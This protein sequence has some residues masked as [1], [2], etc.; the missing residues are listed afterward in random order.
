MDTVQRRDRFAEEIRRLRETYPMVHLRTWTPDDFHAAANGPDRDGKR[1]EADWESPV[2]VGT[3]S[4]L[5]KILDENA[6]GNWLA[7]RRAIRQAAGGQ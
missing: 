4:E 1:G 7:V 2:H 3:A 6:A 5:G